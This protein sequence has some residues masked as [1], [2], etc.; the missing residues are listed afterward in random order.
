MKVFLFILVSFTVISCKTD[1]YLSTPIK[2][3]PNIINLHT[4]LKSKEIL[5]ANNSSLK[6]ENDYFENCLQGLRLNIERKSKLRITDE[7]FFID[8]SNRAIS[9]ELK[10]KHN[11]EGL[12]LLIKLKFKKESYDV[13]SSKYTIFD[14]RMPEPYYRTY[15]SYIPRTNLFVKVI[16]YWEYH[17]LNSGKS[18]QFKIENEKLYELK[19]Q[20]EDI[21]AL[22]E[23]NYKL[24]NTL[25]YQ[26]GSIT[27]NNLVGLSK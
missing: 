9:I 24:L 15:K 19:L 27:A 23:E 7:I 22:L 26:N 20:V 11:V 5:V 21:D 14:N 1:Y 12:L 16:S 13:P 4:N 18:Y 3:I 6:L 17:D 25:F 2:S 10:E 8:S